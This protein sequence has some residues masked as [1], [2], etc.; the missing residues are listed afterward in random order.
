[1]KKTLPNVTKTS[2][3]RA[4]LALI[5]KTLLMVTFTLL[6]AALK[7]KTLLMVTFG[8]FLLRHITDH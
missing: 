5:Y 7:R 4:Y 8:P 2:K 1:M 6:K 3:P